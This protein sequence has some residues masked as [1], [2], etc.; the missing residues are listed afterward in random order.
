M[1]M[2]RQQDGSSIIVSLASRRMDIGKHRGLRRVPDHNRARRGSFEVKETLPER[3]EHSRAKPNRSMQSHMTLAGDPVN[4]SGK[5]TLKPCSQW[6]I[7]NLS[8]WKSYKN[9]FVF[10]QPAGMY[11]VQIAPPR[12]PHLR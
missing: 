12:S 3:F 2:K 5:V 11:N 1:T 10:I 8:S 4:H 7:E 6:N 9:R